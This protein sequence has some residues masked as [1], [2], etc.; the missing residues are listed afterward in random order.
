MGRRLRKNSTPDHD[1][2][3]L[4]DKPKEWTSH[5][6][7]NF[8]RNRYRFNKVG[9]CGT[10][11]PLATGLIVIV[12]GKATK[13]AS[14]LTADDKL[15]VTEMTLGRETDSHDEEGETTREASY[16]H[17]T[18]EQIKQCAIDFTG[19][20]MQTPPMVS[21]LKQNGKK[22]YDLARQGIVVEREA[23]PVT[24]HSL[25]IDKIEL[26]KV[27]YT[28]HCSKGSYVRVLCYDMGLKLETAAYMSN[29]RRTKSGQFSLDNAVTIDH[30][31][32]IER[33]EVEKLII[34]I[35]QVEIA[36]D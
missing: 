5:D 28:L 31:K 16:E 11:D 34:P 24:F 22:L 6:V 26:P 1:G 19:E 27:H 12:I 10:L 3:L 4:V 8:V 9:H 36:E 7:V 20:Q 21:A 15:Y 29:L 30:L 17:V 14:K 2:I 18:E 13:L 32:T 35:D 23:R 25:T 33:T